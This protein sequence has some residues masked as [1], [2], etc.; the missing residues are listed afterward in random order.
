MPFS[1]KDSLLRGH[2]SNSVTEI[3]RDRIV[4]GLMPPGSRLIEREISE[5]LAVSRTPVREAIKELAAEGLVELRPN[6]GAEVA[7]FDADQAGALFEVLAELEAL[8]AQLFV[9]HMSVASLRQLESLQH[10][11]NRYFEAGD[12]ER[13]FTAN[14][15][16]HDLI[17]QGAG[18]EVLAETHHRLLTRSRLGRHMAIASDHARWAE[19][20]DEH[21]HLLIAARRHDDSAAAAI[22]RRHLLN[23]GRALVSA[24]K[25]AGPDQAN[26][27]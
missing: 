23:S 16:I 22:W 15:A 1:D 18:N 2:S 25:A 4:R 13:Y 21:E 26:S 27:G 9:R 3:L 7:G 5:M 19:S 24:I 20:L 8:A 17:I 12:L 14:T 11:L 10:D 6:R